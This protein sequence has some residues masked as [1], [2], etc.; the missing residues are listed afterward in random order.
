MTSRKLIAFTIVFVIFATFVIFFLVSGFLNKHK[1]AIEKVLA[2][3]TGRGIYISGDIQLK[4]FPSISLVVR[5]V[6]IENESWASTPELAHVKRME[7]DLSILPLI[8]GKIDIKRAILSGADIHI[9]VNKK[10]EL[11]LCTRSKSETSDNKRPGNINADAFSVGNIHVT[12]ADIFF[13]D[14]RSGKSLRAKVRTLKIS[15]RD[16]RDSVKLELFALLN[17][18]PLSVSGS[19]GGFY[20]I[21]DPLESTPINLKFRFLDTIANVSG[22]ILDIL[23]GKGLN[24]TLKIRGKSLAAFSG[25]FGLQDVFRQTPFDIKMGISDP[26]PRTYL[27]EKLDASCGNSDLNGNIKLMLSG[28]RPLIIANLSSENLDIGKLFVFHEGSAKGRKSSAARVFSRRP[29]DLFFLD[30][31]NG[32]LQFSCRRFK[33]RNFIFHDLSIDARQKDGKLAVSPLKAFFCEGRI[34]SKIKL[35]R[36]RS[37]VGVY[38]NALIDKLDT[39]K[40]ERLLGCREIV[41]GRLDGEINVRGKGTS[42]AEIMGRL[43][44]KV[45]MIME[46]GKLNIQHVNLLGKDLASSTLRLLSPATAEKSFADI[47]CFVGRFDI[48]NGK[49]YATALV[50]DTGEM[51]VIGEGVVNLR[52]ERLDITL[53][54]S[55]K[56][57]VAGISLSLN[58]LVKPFKL[59]GTLAHPS[60]VIDSARGAML[61]GESLGGLILLGPAG[62]VAPLLNTSS[63]Q[64]N[65]CPVAIK[66]AKKGLKISRKKSKTQSA[67]KIVR[68]TTTTVK[69]TIHSIGNMFKRVLTR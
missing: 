56:K 7:I 19:L 33:T 54:P 43:N 35:A 9:E 3:K 36:K 1:P 10:G 51:T 32:R 46:R 37:G 44:G 22:S 27:L 53:E 34:V 38:C 2:E 50:C 67:N 61:I 57:G 16:F 64:S 5:D 30:A 12:D 15:A 17:G 68:K 13:K 41:Q 23:S 59:G 48:K 8:K 21:T 55:P 45:V 4:L 18:R 40:L 52:T 49:A 28:K 47:N 63:D 6:K 24:L 29:I 42:L 26:E 31:F 65:I 20:T 69:S 25:F 60:L 14:H 66:A 62:V 39:G 58:E 11:N